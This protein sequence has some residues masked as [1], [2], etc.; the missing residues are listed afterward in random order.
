MVLLLVI[1]HL[2]LVKAIKDLRL[3]SA[4]NLEFISNDFIVFIISNL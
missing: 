3:N 2:L 1:G 4:I